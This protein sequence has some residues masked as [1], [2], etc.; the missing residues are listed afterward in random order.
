[1]L[2]HPVRAIPFLHRCSWIVALGD[3]GFFGIFLVHPFHHKLKHFLSLL[4]ERRN[5]AWQV[6]RSVGFLLEYRNPLVIGSLVLAIGLFPYPSIAF[7][8]SGFS[9]A[10]ESIPSRESDHPPS[11]YNVGS[12]RSLTV[13]WRYLNAKRHHCLLVLKMSFMGIPVVSAQQLVV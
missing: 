5:P 1:M 8:P 13:K 9:G 2:E 11:G 7:Q 3:H 6:L 4:L 12:Y 10:C